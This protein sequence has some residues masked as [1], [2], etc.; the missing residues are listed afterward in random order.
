[1]VASFHIFVPVKLVFVLRNIGH[2]SGHDYEYL[3]SSKLLSND[4]KQSFHHNLE[5]HG[6]L[7]NLR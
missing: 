1:M 6:A 3:Y 4:L 7:V 2:T 5:F